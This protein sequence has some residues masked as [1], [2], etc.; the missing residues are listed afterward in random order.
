MKNIYWILSLAFICGSCFDN[1]DN[2]PDPEVIIE[3]PQ[4]FVTTQVSGSV[5]GGDGKL[6]SNYFLS[7]NSEVAEIS[8][9]YFFIEV[10]EAKKKGQTI[11]VVKNGNP[12]GIKTELLVEN[13]INHI[14]IQSH[15]IY[16][17]EIIDISNTSLS[18]SK[19]LIVDFSKSSLVGGHSGN[20]TIE[21]LEFEP[22]ISLSSIGYDKLGNLL[23][24]ESKGGFYLSLHTQDGEQLTIE[25]TDPAQLNIIKTE[26]DDMGLFVFDTQSEIWILVD[27]INSGSMVDIYAEGYYTFGKYSEGVFVEGIV[28]KENKLVAYHPMGWLHNDLSNRFCSTESGNWITVM[29][30]KNDVLV[31]L[32]NPCDESIQDE[33]LTISNQDLNNQTIEI[34]NTNSY[35]FMNTEV[36]DCDG[37]LVSSS[38]FNITTENTTSHYVFSEEGQDR[39][40]TVCDQFSI[41]AYNESTQQIGTDIGWSPSIDEDIPLLSDCTDFTDGFSFIKIGEEKKPFDSFELEIENGKTILKSKGGEIKL[42][43]KGVSARMYAEEEVNVVINDPTFGSKGYYMSCENSQVGCGIKEFNVSQYDQGNNGQI[44]VTFSG[45]LWMQTITPAVAGTFSVEGTIYT[46]L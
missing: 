23:A 14:E 11:K 30:E 40:I 21:Y 10:E 22:S 19:D 3:I 24:L 15:P 31:Y 9:E 36:I 29:P 46:K 12:I 28:S 13:D 26:D 16:N 44:S 45:E 43:F 17:S 37:N 1:V 41:A 39:W 4:V 7:Y 27:N 5:L 8:S 6:V 2:T 33:T 35:Q 25:R 20:T 38:S 42:I 34:D 32:L 18:I